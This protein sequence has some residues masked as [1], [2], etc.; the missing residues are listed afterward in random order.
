M[1]PNKLPSIDARL[2]AAANFVKNGA[3]VA[4][5]GCDHGKLSAYLSA[6]C[7][8]VIAV[9]SKIAPLNV[10]KAQMKK[11]NINNVECR[12][13]D[14][15]LCIE[16]FE[17]DTVVVAGLS[18]KTICEIIE[19]ALWLKNSNT[20]LVLVPATKPHEL[21]L[22]LYA[23]GFETVQEL[24]VQAQGRYYAVMY[25]K[26]TGNSKQLNLLESVI[27]NLNGDAKKGYLI[28]EA[29]KFKKAS[30]DENFKEYKILAEQILLEAQ[31]ARSINN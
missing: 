26:F 1:Q 27:G 13:G 6:K 18:A 15:L 17:A 3:V 12:L 10:A 31:N 25:V 11:C 21:R 2:L 20:S 4:D 30:Q 29:N 14:G 23:N 9:D 7:K 8:K 19:K 24:A 5:I 22:W 16:P 28:C